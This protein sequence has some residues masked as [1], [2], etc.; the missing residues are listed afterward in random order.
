LKF[1]ESGLGRLLGSVCIIKPKI[2]SVGII[3]NDAIYIRNPKNEAALLGK[4]TLKQG[5]ITISYCVSIVDHSEL[6]EADKSKLGSVVK[7]V[8]KDVADF[9][10]LVFS[11]FGIFC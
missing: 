9:A 4:L 6:S 3:L 11:I 2:I 10:L 8:V 5:I 1:N 7:S